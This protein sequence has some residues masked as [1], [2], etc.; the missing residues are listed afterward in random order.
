[1]GEGASDC[2][3]ETVLKGL[4]RARRQAFEASELSRNEMHSTPALTEDDA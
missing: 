3:K 2:E 4:R 1:M